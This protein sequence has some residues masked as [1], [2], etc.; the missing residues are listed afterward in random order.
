[1]HVVPGFDS[2][3][4]A[5][6]GQAESGRFRN[7]NKHKITA[8]ARH[9]LVLQNCQEGMHHA[10]S[11]AAEAPNQLGG[12]HVL[13]NGLLPFLETYATPSPS[14]TFNPLSKMP[15]TSVADLPMKTRALNRQGTNWRASHVVQASNA[16]SAE[17]SKIKK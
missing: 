5:F 2:I 11:E 9:F 7:I 16:F 15:R 13:Y 17:T 14:S 4:I 6:P 8:S 1:M 12:I 10:S 3:Y